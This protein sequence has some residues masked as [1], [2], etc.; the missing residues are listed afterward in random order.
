VTLPRVLVRSSIPAS[1]LFLAYCL[2]L[3]SS[4]LGQE[5]REGAPA[6]QTDDQK[7][8]PTKAKKKPKQSKSPAGA[9]APND[10]TPP[11][12]VEGPI[13]E[14]GISVGRAKVFDNRSLTLMLESLSD[15]LRG[16]QVIDQDPLKKALG[17]L[18]GSQTHDVSRSFSI[19]AGGIPAITTSNT[20]STDI[21]TDASRRMANGIKDDKATKDYVDSA[22]DRKIDEKLGTSRETKTSERTPSVPTLPDLLAAP[23]GSPGFGQNPID[24][25]T[26]QVNLTYQIFNIRMLLE[27]SLTDRIQRED[28]K[29]RLQSVLGF[30]VSI[31]PP[32]DAEGAAAVVEITIDAVNKN[33]VSLVAMMPQEKTYN[34]MALNS[35][36]NAFGGSVV[37]KMVTVGYS[38]RRRGQIFYLYRDNDTLSFERMMTER[39]KLTFGW[40]FRPVLGRKAVAPGMRQMFAVV[41][42][43][44]PDNPDSCDTALQISVRTYWRKYYPNTLTTADRSG[45]GPW[46]YVARAASLGIHRSVP[47]E[48]TAWRKETESTSQVNVFATA[49]YQDD[50]EPTVQKVEWTKI[51]DKTALIS[52]KGTNFFTGTTVALGGSAAAANIVI[53]STQAMDI[54]TPVENVGA[55]TAMIIGRYGRARALE[56]DG[57]CVHP[58]T[59]EATLSMP[60]G[61]QRELQALVTGCD[62]SE[63]ER[64]VV[65]F[66]SGKMV[67]GKPYVFM[68][69]DGTHIVAS[70]P[71]DFFAKG[72]GTIKIVNTFRKDSLR[73][74]FPWY[75]NPYDIQ[76][77][78][79]GSKTLVF[80]RRKDGVP[81]NSELFGTAPAWKVKFAGADVTPVLTIPSVMQLELPA[82]DASGPVALIE[83]NKD[84][85]ND[86]KLYLLDL[87]PAQPKPKAAVEPASGTSLTINQNDVSKLDFSGEKIDSVSTV[88]VEGKDPLKTEYNDEKKLLSVYLTQDVTKLPGKLALQFRDSAGKQV[89]TLVLEVK[90][91]PKAASNPDK[92]KASV[93]KEKK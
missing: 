25:L 20:A 59:K 63:L 12:E 66:A 92:P 87:P 31:D 24:L 15:T 78:P 86:P 36:S 47:E 71:A 32:R 68:D 19:T 48:K 22:I 9:T 82:A 84:K 33:P 62:A 18:Q 29:P 46:P 2:L 45:I 75:D 74:E 64:Q 5:A 7:I 27:R 38:E 30:N 70:I 41:S 91:T 39:N 34:A 8:K 90:A 14:N 89:A 79:A 16:L 35:K 61:G 11:N 83:P 58:M 53:K 77:M 4:T 52:V 81:F 44:A 65:V 13:G 51:D 93:P 28:G 55:G 56:V 17:L 42:L 88:K 49:K 69:K 26:D 76:R 37:A 54:I 80:I 60:F 1:C 85:P 57:G 72:E 40:Q 43:P 6:E 10:S 23:T 73:F 50:L 3:A 67:P 21:S